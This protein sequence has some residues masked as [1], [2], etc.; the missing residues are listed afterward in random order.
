MIL[1]AVWKQT[2]CVV[3][4]E[5]LHKITIYFWNFLWTFLILCILY[6]DLI[7][8]IKDTHIKLCLESFKI[9]LYADLI[10]FRVFQFVF[11]DNC[12]LKK[13]DYWISSVQ[14]D[15][16]KYQFDFIFAVV[17]SFCNLQSTFFTLWMKIN[18]WYTSCIITDCWLISITSCAE[19]NDVKLKLLVSSDCRKLVSLSLFIKTC[20]SWFMRCNV[21]YTVFFLDKFFFMN[22]FFVFLLIDSFF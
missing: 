14:S 12:T 22:F 17:K 15:S 1:L 19:N 18:S 5:H 16:L 4:W 2:I 6:T 8:L 9:L 11:S 13:T 20:S 21:S 7:Y 10:I 3:F